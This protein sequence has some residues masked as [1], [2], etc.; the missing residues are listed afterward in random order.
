VAIL[1]E[2]TP[3]GADIQIQ[4]YLVDDSGDV[5]EVLVAGTEVTVREPVRVKDSK[6][7]GRHD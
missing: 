6:R 3:K 4:A 2:D 1:D 7:R 5:C